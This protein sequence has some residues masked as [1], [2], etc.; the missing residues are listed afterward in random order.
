M[1]LDVGTMRARWDVEPPTGAA[2]EFAHTL[3]DGASFHSVMMGEGRCLAGFSQR[4]MLLLMDEFARERG[5]SASGR[6]EV[7]E[8]VA[9][10]PWSGWRDALDPPPS[11]PAEYGERHVGGRVELY[12]AW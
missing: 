2:Y 7:W 8:W 6:R 11:D 5:L 4:R 3:R 1:G 9:S 10:L 12:F